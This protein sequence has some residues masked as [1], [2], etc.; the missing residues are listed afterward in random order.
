ML[1]HAASDA[2]ARLAPMSGQ[3]MPPARRALAPSVVGIVGAPGHCPAAASPHWI[4][5]GTAHRGSRSPDH[6][7]ASLQVLRLSELPSPYQYCTL[8]IPL[9]DIA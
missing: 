5:V 2:V 6:N 4:L 1:K 9:N 8:Y 7:H 3:L